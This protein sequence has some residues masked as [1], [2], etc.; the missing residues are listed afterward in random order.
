[1]GN[2]RLRYRIPL[3]VIAILMV[4]TLTVGSSYA[5]WTVTKSQ[6]TANVINSGCFRIEFLEKSSSINLTNTYPIKDEKGMATTPYKFTV[7]NTCTIDADYMIYLN[8]VNL[9]SNINK[10]SDDL[11]K[12]SIIKE[13]DSTS[14]ANLL[15]SATINSDKALFTDEVLN[16]ETYFDKSYEIA[17]GTLAASSSDGGTDGGEA[18]Y[19]LRLWIDSSATTAIN[20]YNF[21]A[22]VYSVARVSQQ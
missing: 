16:A 10:I 5:L 9:D 1:M 15:S 6:S 17:G 14:V 2:M 21:E 3:A 18:T 8:T 20:N 13:G 11:I 12:Y 7:K 19:Y 4:I 22:A